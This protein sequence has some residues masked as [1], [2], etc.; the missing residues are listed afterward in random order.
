VNVNVFTPETNAWEPVAGIPLPN[1]EA[2][3]TESNEEYV[4]VAAVAPD[5]SVAVK[6]RYAV[7]PGR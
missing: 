3:T 4:A 5:E 1:P 2:S 6:V 7:S